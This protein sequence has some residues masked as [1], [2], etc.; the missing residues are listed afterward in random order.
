MISAGQM[1]VHHFWLHRDYSS[2]IGVVFRVSILG[3]V[4]VYNSVNSYTH[5]LNC[6]SLLKAWIR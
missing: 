5:Q 4:F 6:L 2:R 3:V 1:Y